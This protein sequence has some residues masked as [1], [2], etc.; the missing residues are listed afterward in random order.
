M[1]LDPPTPEVIAKKA[2]WGFGASPLIVDDI[3][4]AADLNGKVHALRAVTGD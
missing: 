1:Y 2:E 4:Y 3:V